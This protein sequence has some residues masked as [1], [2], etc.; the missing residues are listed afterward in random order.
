MGFYQRW[1]VPRLINLAMRNRSLDAYRQRTIGKAQGFVLEIG[2][3]SGQNLPLYGSVDHVCAMDTS[4][5]LL[6]LATNRIAYV[7]VPVSL[8]RASAEQ[9]PVANAVFDTIVT[10]WT[11]CSIPDPVAALVEVRRVLRPGG[12]LVFVEHGLSPESRVARWQHRLTPCWKR[13]AGGCHLDRK[14]D[15]L[16]RAAGFR[17]SD[18]ETRYMD[19]P[20]LMTV[21]YQ[22]QAIPEPAGRSHG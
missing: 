16:I 13:I 7:S 18:I 6:R 5:E 15:D 20:K 3:G 11:L 12:N 19:G 10:T 14:M 21:M 2:V 1:I 9:I 17:L 22:G 8:V 4:A